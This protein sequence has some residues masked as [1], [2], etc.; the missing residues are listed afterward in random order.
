MH[1]R[2]AIHKY[3]A[4]VDFCLFTAFSKLDR[5]R[6]RD[7]VRP[8]MSLNGKS[9]IAFFFFVNA[10]QNNELLIGSQILTDLPLVGHRRSGSQHKV[11]CEISAVDGAC[12]FRR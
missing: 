8:L 2:C 4:N 11:Q 3:E 12:L 7:L 5:D 9:G 10:C 1:K 6:D